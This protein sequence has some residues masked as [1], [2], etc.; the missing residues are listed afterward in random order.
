MALGLTRATA[1]DKIRLME[2][3]LTIHDSGEA[4]ATC[5]CGLWRLLRVAPP[6]EPSED[7]MRDINEAHEAH[8]AAFE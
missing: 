6:G 8:V 1:R 5:S 4:D 7:R 2:H 3:E